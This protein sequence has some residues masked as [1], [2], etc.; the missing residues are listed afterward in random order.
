[1]A[2]GIFWLLVEFPVANRLLQRDDHHLSFLEKAIR[3]VAKGQV[4]TRDL[5]N[6]LLRRHCLVDAAKAGCHS[7]DDGLV[8][9][10]LQVGSVSGK[11]A[12]GELDARRRFPRFDKKCF[13]K[14]P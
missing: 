12:F 11:K 8:E 10:A 5:Q 2:I 9:N 3:G 1:M 14:S 4:S 13:A 6:A 7:L